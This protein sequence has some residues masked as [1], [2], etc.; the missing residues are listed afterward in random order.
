MRPARI[1]GRMSS[2][3]RCG[4]PLPNAPNGPGCSTCRWPRSVR[5]PRHRRE[6]TGPAEMWAGP[7]CGRLLA[8]SGAVVVKVESPG[9]PDGTRAGD[10]AFF[11]WMNS[12][13]FSYAVDFDRDRKAVHNLLA[14]ADVV[15]E[16]SR[17]AALHRRGLGPLDVSARPGRVWVRITGHGARANRV[18][19]GDD[20][21]VAGG[22]VG[23]DGDSPVFSGDA[24]ADPLTGLEATAA[25]LGSLARGGAEVIEMSMAAVAAQYAAVGGPAVALH[26]VPPLV[27]AAA[28]E[29]GADNS[30]VEQ[31]VAERLCAPC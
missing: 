5:P 24:I 14:V 12:G 15:L 22:L 20:A 25:V 31:L 27:A 17:P 1:P 11:D 26:P 21:A 19:F 23:W 13:K 18:A 16:G 28:A 10:R 3:G 30:A 8:R 7:L 4:E 29:L 6:L 9:R 2:A